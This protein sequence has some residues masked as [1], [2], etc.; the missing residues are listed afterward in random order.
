MSEFNRAV[1]W[2]FDGCAIR[3]PRAGV[4]V[5]RRRVALCRLSPASGGT[6]RV[7]EGSADD[8]PKLSV[9]GGWATPGGQPGCAPVSAQ[10]WRQSGAGRRRPGDERQ[11]HTGHPRSLR[12]PRL[13]SGGSLWPGLFRGARVLPALRNKFCG[14]SG[15]RRG[16]FFALKIRSGQGAGTRSAGGISADQDGGRSWEARRGQDLQPR[17]VERLESCERE[18]IASRRVQ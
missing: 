14:A 10:L 11:T 4:T 17:K 18:V 7:S 5:F 6:I 3:F 2:L 16:G 12:T 13:D 9:Y 1:R 15:R 8:N